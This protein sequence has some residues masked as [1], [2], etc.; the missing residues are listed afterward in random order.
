[1]RNIG[2]R[3]PDSWIYLIKNQIYKSKLADIIDRR[4][5]IPDRAAKFPVC[6]LQFP[7]TSTKFPAQEARELAA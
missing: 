6:P 7:D 3:E 5:Q 2:G 4:C 1:M